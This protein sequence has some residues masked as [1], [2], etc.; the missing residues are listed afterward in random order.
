MN[1]GMF[2]LRQILAIEQRLLTLGGSVV[3]QEDL[4]IHGISLFNLPAKVP[5]CDSTDLGR[6]GW[7]AVAAHE[8]VLI[9]QLLKRAH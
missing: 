7:H 4:L 9:D 2:P 3:G 6:L 5:S 8:Q 1:F